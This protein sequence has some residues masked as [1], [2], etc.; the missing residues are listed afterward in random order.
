MSTENTRRAFLKVAT[1]SAAGMA[2]SSDRRQ[3][4][5][6]PR[7]Q[8][9]R[10][11]RHRR[12][13]RPVPR[14]LLPAFQKHAK[15]LNF[16]IVAV[17]DIWSL[18]REQGAAQLREAGRRDAGALPQQRRAVRSQG[19][20]RRHRRDRRLPARAPRR[21]GGARRAATPTSRSRS[22]TPWPTRAPLRKAV[23]GHRQD[24][25]DRHAAAQRRRT[26]SSAYEFLKSG[27]FG[28]IVDG[29]DDLERQSAGTLAP[30][31]RRAAA[32]RAGHGLETLSD[33]SAGR[34][35]RSAASI[36]SSG[37][38]GRIRP[39]FPD[40]WL[41]HQIDTVHWFTGLPRPRSVVANGGIYLWNDG[42]KNWDTITAVFDYG[43]LDDPSKGF[44]VLYSSRQTNAAGDVKEMYYSNGG[45]L[46]SRQEQGERE[47]GLTAALRRR[48]A[49]RRTCCRSG[50]S[51]KRR[52]R[53]PR[54]ETGVDDSTSANMRNWMECVRSRK[55]PNA[56]IEA[57]YSHSVALCMTIAAMQTGQ[58]VT[59]DDAAAGSRPGE[60]EEGKG[61]NQRV[62]NPL[63][64][65][66]ALHCD[67]LKP[68][69]R[70]SLGRP[71]P[72]GHRIA[73]RSPPETKLVQRASSVPD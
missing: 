60:W 64:P 38:S 61:D 45:M 42:R 57:G 48:W 3:L 68:A 59:F 10:P 34:A 8:R 69:G 35:V 17:S 31:E 44:Q 23:E 52:R 7:R 13:L 36:S 70:G 71:R 40:Q 22:P 4:R 28:D 73:G 19:R 43:P 54:A 66:G 41:V 56:N 26:T 5:A 29:R 12:L 21:R 46:E 62:G 18:R 6:H 50:R 58:R 55:T 27:Q 14:R 16:E 63:A 53:R 20:R 11:R 2:L 30:A 32:A 65:P 24:R 39:A 47:G 67:P 9:P 15:E 72:S 1:A 37:C 49:C 51:P 25:P 33:E